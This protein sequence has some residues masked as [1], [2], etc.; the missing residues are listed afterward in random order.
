[1]FAEELFHAWKGILDELEQIVPQQPLTKE[2]QAGLR[3]L[4]NRSLKGVQNLHGHME[5][6]LCLLKKHQFGNPSEPLVD[7]TD[8]WLAE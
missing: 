1:M 7:F 5:I 6:V 2:V 3:A 4:K 8:R